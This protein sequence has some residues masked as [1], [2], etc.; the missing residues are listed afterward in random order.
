MSDNNEQGY[1]RE[2]PV[3]ANPGNQYD[4][5]TVQSSTELRLEGLEDYQIQILEDK[6]ARS[7]MPGN[8]S[9][10]LQPTQMKL[11]LWRHSDLRGYTDSVR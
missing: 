4:S 5:Y 8:A 1:L 2:T 9:G 3:E 11:E 10:V 7:L 6:N